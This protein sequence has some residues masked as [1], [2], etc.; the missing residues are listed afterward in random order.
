MTTNAQAIFG[1]NFTWGL[2]RRMTSTSVITKKTKVTAVRTTYMPHI[3]S[4]FRRS[5]SQRPPSR[6]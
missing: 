1:R 4:A 6:G 5:A 2:G 3:V